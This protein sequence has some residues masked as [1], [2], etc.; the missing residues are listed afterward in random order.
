MFTFPV[1]QVR[2]VI[3]RGQAD[4]TAN[5]GFRNPHYGLAPGKDEK[6]GLWLVGDEGVYL[7]S[8]GKL[9]DGQRPIVVYAEE[10]DPTTN[11]DYW[12]YKR[13]HFGG[14]D[15]ID[16]LD[17]ADLL[18]LIEASPDATH[19]RIEMTDASMSIVLIRR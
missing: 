14:D 12:H 17:A 15:G 18:R 5:G 6:P 13:Q 3:A 2:A 7:L 9:A 1:T 8:N 11:P 10:C 4:A 16:F 19:V